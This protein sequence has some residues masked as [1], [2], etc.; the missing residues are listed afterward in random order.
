M[1]LS[2]HELQTLTGYK[3]PGAQS[4][5]LRRNGI[6]HW[7]TRNGTGPVRVLRSALEPAQRE[8]EPGRTMP[9]LSAL[10]L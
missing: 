5:W 6:R 1:F 8:R 3:L 9:D 2:D 7:R 10:G 4:A